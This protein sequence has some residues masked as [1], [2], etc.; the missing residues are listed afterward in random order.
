MTIKGKL[1]DPLFELGAVLPGEA[2]ERLK[3]ILADPMADHSPGQLARI[4]EA[5]IQIGTAINIE[6]REHVYDRIVGG[7][8]EGQRTA[9]SG[10]VFQWNRPRQDTRVNTAYLRKTFPVNE[11]PELYKK[12]EVKDSV[13]ITMVDKG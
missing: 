5:L 13:S 11:Y 6:V 9:D 8:G 3:D 1:N 12:V 7:I 10:V 4:G 2:L